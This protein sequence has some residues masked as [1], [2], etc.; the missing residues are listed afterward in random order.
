[1]YIIKL[2][3]LCIL[4][5]I[6]KSSLITKRCFFIYSWSVLAILFSDAMK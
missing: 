3:I 1:M 4:F 2:Y 5:A 6:N